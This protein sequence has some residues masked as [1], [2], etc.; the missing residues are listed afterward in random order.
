[1]LPEFFQG[2]ANFDREVGE[3]RGGLQSSLLPLVH[4]FTGSLPAS[5]SGAVP[6]GP[7]E[8]LFLSCDA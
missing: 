3:A 2:A 5:R 6:P 7:S 4:S 8:H 1:M